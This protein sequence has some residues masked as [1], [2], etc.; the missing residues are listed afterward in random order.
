MRKYFPLHNYSTREEG[1]IVIYQLEG[2]ASMWLDQFLQ[3]QH[4]DEKKVTWREFK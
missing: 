1:R 2:K 4:I 3:V